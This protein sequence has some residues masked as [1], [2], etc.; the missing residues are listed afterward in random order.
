MVTLQLAKVLF[1]N[2]VMIL[3]EEF[4]VPNECFGSTTIDPPS[5]LVIEVDVTSKTGLEVYRQFEVPVVWRFEN[6]ELQ[7][8]VLENGAYRESA[9]SQD[10]YLRVTDISLNYSI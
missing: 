2:M 5:D 3:L 1:G 7:I 10:T 4:R 6:G 9:V 8:S